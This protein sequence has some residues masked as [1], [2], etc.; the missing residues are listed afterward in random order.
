MQ[1]QFCEFFELVYDFSAI[2]LLFYVR[3]DMGFING[4]MVVCL[5]LSMSAFPMVMHAQLVDFFVSKPRCLL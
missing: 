3:P 4:K 5:K 1:T 2:L